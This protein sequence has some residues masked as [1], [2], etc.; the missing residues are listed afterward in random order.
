MRR[1]LLMGMA[2]GAALALASVAA[3]RIWLKEEPRA[4]HLRIA[5]DNFDYVLAPGYRDDTGP[6]SAQLVRRCG[7]N[8]F[9]LDSAIPDRTGSTF[10]EIGTTPRAKLNCLIG[11]AR[12]QGLSMAIVDGMD[13]TS[14]ECLPGRP[15]RFQKADGNFGACPEREPDPAPASGC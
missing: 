5:D 9:T 2:C 14:F 13:M 8:A 4:L 3:A 1:T 6:I 15:S 10:V 11:E 7:I 12:L